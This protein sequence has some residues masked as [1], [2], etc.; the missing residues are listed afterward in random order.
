MALDL[1]FGR[2]NGSTRVA[3]PVSLKKFDAIVKRIGEAGLQRIKDFIS[4]NI[5][6]G[7]TFSVATKFGRPWDQTPLELIY[8]AAQQNEG[9]AA[10]FIGLLVYNYLVEDDPRHWECAKSE[11]N[12]RD[13]EVNFYWLHRHEQKAA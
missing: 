5:S 8:K 7:K 1:V 10:M 13:V 12:G 2:E 3:K 4:E 6:D 11:L 9:Q